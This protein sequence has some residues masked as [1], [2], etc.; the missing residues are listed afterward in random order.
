MELLRPFHP[1]PAGDF[2]PLGGLLDPPLSPSCS[3]DVSGEVGGGNDK[4]YVAVGTTLEKGIGLIRW[5]VERFSGKEIC[6]LHVHRPSP[7]IPTLLGKLPASQANEEVVISFRVEERKAMRKLL[8][9][10]LAVC[11]T[12]KVEASVIVSQDEH[13]PTGIVE[14]VSRHGIRRLVMGAVPENCMKVK[15]GSSKAY[16][17][18]RNVPCFCEI[19]FVNRG[20][21]LWTRD[22]T[23]GPSASGTCSQ[24]Q[25]SSSGSDACGSLGHN[26]SNPAPMTE[27]A[28]DE[29]L[30]PETDSYVSTSG[31]L[32]QNRQGSYSPAGTTSCS[33]DTFTEEMVFEDS[34]MRSVDGSSCDCL[35]ETWEEADAVNMEAR[36]KEIDRKRIEKEAMKALSKVKAFEAACGRETALRVEAEDKLDTILQE[37]QKALE[38]KE[39]LAR[40]LQR[41][42]RNVALLDSRAGEATRRSEET[43][44]ELRVIEVSIANLRMEKQRIQRQKAEAAHWLDRWKNRGQSG[45]SRFVGFIT[46]PREDI[47][48]LAEFSLAELE[49]ATC[50]FSESFKIG[51]SGFGCV[52][53]GEMLGRTVA[54][55]KLHPHN[56]QGQLEF[57]KEV[58]V[59]SNL[60]HPHLVSLL[61]ACSEAGSLVYEY[62]PNGSL[63]DRLFRKN[64]CPPLRWKDRVRIIAEIASALCFL[65]SSKPERI[66]HGNLKPENIL[67]DSKLGCKICDFGICRLVADETLRCPSFRH[68]SE[69]KN[70]FPYTDPEFHRDG[71]LTAKSDVYSFGL[72]ILQLLTG[73]LPLGLV[74]EV[75]KAVSHGKLEALLDLSAGEWPS[76]VVTRLLELGLQCCETIGRV[77]PDLTPSLVREFELL[78]TLKERPIP[79]FFLCPILREIMHDPQIAADGF[80][81]ERAALLVWL[82][83]GR[84]TSPMTNLKLSNLQL[85]P[86]HALR[87]AIQ[88]WLCKSCEFS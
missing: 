80:T 21:H 4:V 72:V 3:P 8:R 60:Q 41:T 31:Y 58:E 20:K 77:R 1:H 51:Q 67:L 48:E 87:Q 59:L 83:N 82:Q 38:E 33:G 85:T 49:S 69:P 36:Q 12:L 73:R 30:N 86:N 46:G 43:A 74:S 75:R 44:E 25:T 35:I 26:D 32:L 76:S 18:A 84:D 45:P 55:K 39:E 5:S 56:V 15:K 6:V 24:R 10:Y 71:V 70:A 17:A 81:Y 11:A 63:L 54:I 14:M 50:Y 2:L 57:Q 65:H 78:H 64:T 42:M 22:A 88:D 79:S 53:K 47:P 62:L 19:S 37:Q 9:N 7:L 28:Q 66:V 29:A 52:Y 16:F 13:V 68:T 34:V 40:K 27:H 23:E 61:G